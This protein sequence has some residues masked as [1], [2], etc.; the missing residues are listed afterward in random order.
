MLYYLRGER[1]LGLRLRDRLCVLLGVRAVLDFSV[2]AVHRARARLVDALTRAL[3]ARRGPATMRA[4]RGVRE[5]ASSRRSR[6][7]T[8]RHARG[9]ARFRR[10]ALAGRD[11]RASAAC[12]YASRNGTPAAACSI[13]TS[14]AYIDGSMAA[15]M[16]WRIPCDAREQVG[17][18]APARRGRVR[19]R[20]TSRPWNCRS[21]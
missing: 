10:P 21:R 1:Q 16:R 5:S 11:R 8:G 14:V 12:R 3:V 13:A 2:R 4:V 17:Q 9:E 18:R 20:G 15:R 7:G 19:S 6:R